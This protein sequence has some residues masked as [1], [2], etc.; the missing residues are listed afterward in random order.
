MVTG[1]PLI[2]NE[3]PQDVDAD[4]YRELYVS[5]L[6]TI[7]IR[8]VEPTAGISAN[9][10]YEGPTLATLATPSTMGGRLRDHVEGLWLRSQ[11]RRFNFVEFV[12]ELLPKDGQQ[13]GATHL[14]HRWRICLEGT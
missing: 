14:I 10:A 8:H 3:R 7:R 5:I 9:D 2:S 11:N 6:R 13:I 12:D 1:W 4:R